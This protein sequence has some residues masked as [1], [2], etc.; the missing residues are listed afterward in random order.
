VVDVTGHVEVKVDTELGNAARA[1]NIEDAPK[2]DAE[3][4]GHELEHFD[5]SI[6]GRGNR[7]VGHFNGEV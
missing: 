4:I 2:S 6:Q 5:Q 7:R 3:A 1:N